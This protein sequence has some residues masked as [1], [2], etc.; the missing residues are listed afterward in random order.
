MDEAAGALT[1]THSQRLP[2]LILVKKDQL[3]LFFLPFSLLW[4]YTPV[5][6]RGQWLCFWDGSA[7]GRFLET[8]G[9]LLL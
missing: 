8:K 1:H 3:L 4:S 2:R 7:Y 5:S 6:F 9:T